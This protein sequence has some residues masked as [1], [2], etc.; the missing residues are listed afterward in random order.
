MQQLVDEMGLSITVCHLPPGTRTWNK[1]EQSLFAWIS[2]NWRGQPLV[3]YAVILKL[4]G[5]TTT[6]AGLT[7]QCQLDT[8]LYPAGRQIADEDM[9]TSPYNRTHSTTNGTLPF[10][11]GP[12]QLIL[13]LLDGS[14]GL[15]DGPPAIYDRLGTQSPKPPEN[16]RT[17]SL[18]AII[19]IIIITISSGVITE[20]DEHQQ[21][22]CVSFKVRKC[23]S[24]FG[25]KMPLK[26]TRYCAGYLGHLFVKDWRRA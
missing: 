16:D 1:I 26:A 24:S 17:M 4:I 18:I 14:L 19:L 20:I 7:V 15:L 9:A 10:H 25:Q 2:Q 8:N 13:L 21:R 6:E 5:A 11:L 22:T 23:C 3:S 12:L